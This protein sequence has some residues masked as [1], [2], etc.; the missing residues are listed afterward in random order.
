M[1]DKL[2]IGVI[3]STHGLRGEVNVYP[4]TDE[5]DRFSRTDKVLVAAP[6][7]ERE[8]AIERVAYFKG[9]PIVKF[10][11]IDTIEDA[12]KIRGAV[13]SVRREDAI[14]L[15][16]GEY[17]IGD[18][19]GCRVLLPD[20]EEY[21]MLKDVLR[22]GANDVYMVEKTDG[23]TGYIPAVREFVLS[24]EPEKQ[25]IRVRVLREI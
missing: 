10:A 7:G 13:I 9:R 4:T 8:L 15:A 6:S 25:E 3:S 11:G 17:F 2:E 23:T 12:Q 14:P 20:G 18:L 22:T 1:L 19:I 5:P 24:V 16:E 21:G